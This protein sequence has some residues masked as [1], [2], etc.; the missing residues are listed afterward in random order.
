MKKKKINLDMVILD[1]VGFY[2]HQLDSLSYLLDGTP[3]VF[4]TNWNNGADWLLR[5]EEYNEGLIS[6]YEASKRL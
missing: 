6:E 1:E 5:E 2:D 4:S 3:H